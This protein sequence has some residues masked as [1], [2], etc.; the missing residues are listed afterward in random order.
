MA[1]ARIFAIVFV[2]LASALTAQQP[3]EVRVTFTVTDQTGAPIGNAHI[4]VDPPS[5]GA[6]DAARAD[7]RGEAIRNL[8]PGGHVLV[9]SR[10]GFYVW[11]ERVDLAPGA[12]QSVAAV[13]QVGSAIDVVPVTAPPVLLDLFPADPSI[14]LQAVQQLESL[15]AVQSRRAR[16][17]RWH[18][19]VSK[20]NPMP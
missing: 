19:R 6:V 1:D 2:L 17:W 4:Q 12:D 20:P 3:Q 11:R 7:G 8:P 18:R 15:P 14:P 9:V 5:R 16:W 10:E 13:L